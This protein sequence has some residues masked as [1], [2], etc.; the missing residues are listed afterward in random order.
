MRVYVRRSAGGFTTIFSQDWSFVVP[1]SS[2]AR[3]VRD[4]ENPYDVNKMKTVELCGREIA[5]KALLVL[6]VTA[7]AACS[8]TPAAPGL[9]SLSAVTHMHTHVWTV[10]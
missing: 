3:M 5:L 1:L 10:V 7:I 9:R 2:H 4:Y 6:A 8:P